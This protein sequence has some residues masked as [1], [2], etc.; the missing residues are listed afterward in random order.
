[1]IERTQTSNFSCPSTDFTFRDP[2]FY[3]LFRDITTLRFWGEFSRLLQIALSSRSQTSHYSMQ[4]ITRRAMLHC[5]LYT[6]FSQPHILAW[7]V[8]Y[9]LGYEHYQPLLRFPSPM[10]IRHTHA[11]L[12]SAFT[13]KRTNCDHWNALDSV[14]TSTRLARVTFFHLISLL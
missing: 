9:S 2:P 12:G 14:S 13:C 1:M 11:V 5:P 3:S 6:A 4:P 10:S 8:P 7:T